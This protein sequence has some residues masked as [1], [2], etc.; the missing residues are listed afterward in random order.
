MPKWPSKQ[1]ALK[2]VE[3]VL[4]VQ[5]GLALLFIK[6][7]TILR[8]PAAAA[9]QRGG[10]SKIFKEKKVFQMKALPYA[11]LKYLYLLHDCM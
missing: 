2:G 1:A 9:H 10:A 4:V 7:F 5:F 8:C 6:H 11:T 3:F